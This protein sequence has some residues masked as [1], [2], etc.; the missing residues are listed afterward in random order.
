[1]SECVESECSVNVK[2]LLT[3]FQSNGVSFLQLGQRA[4]LPFTQRQGFL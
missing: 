4:A 2:L 1:M 3:Y